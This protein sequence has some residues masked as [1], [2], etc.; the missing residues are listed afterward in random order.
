VD[1][2]VRVIS[3]VNPPHQRLPLMEVC[4]LF[5]DAMV[6][7]RGDDVISALKSN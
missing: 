5:V 2:L 3:A 6:L 7:D 1:V 4:K